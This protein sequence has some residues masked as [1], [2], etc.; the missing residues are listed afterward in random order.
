LSDLT[1]E[2]KTLNYGKEYVVEMAV[3]WV[4]MGGEVDR[5][6]TVMDVIPKVMFGYR[7]LP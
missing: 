6:G 5:N 1:W 7:E 4:E 2:V 3:S